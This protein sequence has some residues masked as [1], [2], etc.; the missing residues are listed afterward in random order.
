MTNPRLPLVRRVISVGALAAMLLVMLPAPAMAAGSARRDGGK[1]IYVGGGEVNSLTVAYG[2]GEYTFTD[3]GT[4]LSAGPGCTAAGGDFWNPG[5]TRIDCGGSGVTSIVI[6]TRGGNDTAMVAT[7]TT[8]PSGV[9]VVVDLGDGRDRWEGSR[10]TADIV[11]GGGGNDDIEGKGANDVLRG[12]GGNDTIRGGSGND[13]VYGG[14][15][16]DRV[17]GDDGND[18]VNGEGGNDWAEGNRGRDV[19]HGG[20]DRDLVSG[21][22]G[23]DRIIGGDG[24]D[25]LLDDVGVGRASAL[26]SDVLIGGRG[27]DTADYS[28]RQGVATPLRLSLDRRA[29]DGAKGEGDQIGPDRSVENIIGGILSDTIIGNDRA[30]VLQGRERADMIRGLGGDDVLRGDGGNDGIEGNGGNDLLA[31]WWG[32][33]TLVGG[34]GGDYLQGGVDDDLLIAD[35]GARDTVS[36][37]DDSDRALVDGR[38]VV[39]RLCERVAWR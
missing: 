22:P 1:L 23:G 7:G 39:T 11:N 12:A 3:G 30:N 34:G 26:G 31:G 25:R 24:K 29:N 10:T 36:C 28:Y 8:I 20:A 6:R 13:T 9:K 19:V 16:A 15:G 33:D 21:G 18:N 35:D 37:G 2:G 5:A 17:Y 32:D 4:N 38:D 14:P 27:I